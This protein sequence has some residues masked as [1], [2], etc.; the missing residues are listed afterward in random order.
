MKAVIVEDQ[1]FFL[2]LLSAAL[3]GRGIEI[4]GRASTQAEALRIIDE[5]A[6]DLALLD[7]RLTRER[8]DEGLRI[9]ELVR[10]RYPE[11]G[12]LVLSSYLEPAYAERLLS[13]D[14]PP[15]AIGYLGKE[16]LGDLEELV[17]ALTRIARGGVVIDRHIISTLMSRRR[18]TDPLERLTPH[19]RRILE[20]VAEGRS[21]V[22]IAQALGTK[23][24]TVERQLS[25][26]FDKL[27]LAE[28]TESDRRA[29]NLRVLA[30]LTFLRSNAG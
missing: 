26:I 8:D 4:T 2:D 10:A 25:A 27:G 1:G 13:I 23:I 7:I 21:N 22:G 14:E 5:T 6:P 3:G 24:S 9:A 17:E 12:L 29:I 16:R 15:R 28:A 19:E 18:V 20:L 30:T 11:V